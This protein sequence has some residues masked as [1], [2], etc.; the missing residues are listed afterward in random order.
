M[1]V[2]AYLFKFQPS[3]LMDMDEEDLEFWRLEADLVVKALKSK[4]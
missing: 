2:F 1:G 3:E 4:D